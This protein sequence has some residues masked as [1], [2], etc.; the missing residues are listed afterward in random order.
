WSALPLDSQSAPAHTGRG[1]NHPIR[2]IAFQP[3]HCG[4]TFWDVAKNCILV[5]GLEECVVYQYNQE[6]NKLIQKAP[7][8]LKGSPKNQVVYN[9]IEIPMGKGI[10][11]AAVQSQKIQLVKNL[12]NDSRYIVDDQKR[13]SEIAV[14]ILVE[15][16]TFGV[17]DS[18]HSK[19]NF[20]T[21]WHARVLKKIAQLCSEKISRYLLAEEIRVKIA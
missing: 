7:A 14:P 19:K 13:L 4:K 1:N 18:E 6:K 9:A 3:K 20:F 17:I 16:K 10:V 15:G 21:H 12:R 2:H 5:L 8:G 11:G